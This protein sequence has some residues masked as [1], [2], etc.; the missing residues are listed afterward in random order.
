MFYGSQGWKQEFPV[1]PSKNR[2]FHIRNTVFTKV[3]CTM[4]DDSEKSFLTSIIFTWMSLNCYS[5]HPHFAKKKGESKCFATQ[6]RDLVSHLRWK[7]RSVALNFSKRVKTLTGDVMEFRMRSSA[8]AV[9]SGHTTLLSPVAA[10]ASTEASANHSHKD[11]WNSA[12]RE[13]EKCVCN[14][15]T[16][17]L[18][19][20]LHHFPTHH[21][22]GLTKPIPI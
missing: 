12:E 20:I 10:S 1:M 11:S 14:C 22:T 5:R 9:T 21:Y 17:F 16:E 15:Y 19:L 6:L 2:H 18:V 3:Y 4:L 7:T 13:C 8:V